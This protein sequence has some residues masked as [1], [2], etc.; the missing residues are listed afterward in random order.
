VRVLPKVLFGVAVL[1]LATAFLAKRQNLAYSPPV[2]ATI[3]E[4]TKT[5]VSVAMFGASLWVILSTKPYSQ[6]DKYWAYAAAGTVFAYW[7][8]S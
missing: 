4:W 1:L 6:N 3:Q 8:T 5:I 2:S 7:L